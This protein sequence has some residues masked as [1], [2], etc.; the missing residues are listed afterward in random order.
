[1]ATEGEFSHGTDAQMPSCKLSCSLKSHGETR[2]RWS[3][4]FEQRQQVLD[5]RARPADQFP[6]VFLRQGQIGHVRLHAAMVSVNRSAI[7]LRNNGCNMHLPRYAGT[8]SKVMQIRDV[9][10]EVHDALA[11]AARAQGLSLTKYILRELEHLARRPQVVRE[12]VATIRR[13][14]QMVQGRPSREAILTVLHE[15]RGA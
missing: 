8:M 12:N 14:Q 1:M 7:P 10:D 11:R 13:T 5:A 4:S 6:P 3:V 15:G 2:V 9:P